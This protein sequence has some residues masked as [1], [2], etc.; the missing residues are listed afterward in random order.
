MNFT[1]HKHYVGGEMKS[2]KLSCKDA[3][4]L[5]AATECKHPSS[6]T[7]PP[8]FQSVRLSDLVQRFREFSMLVIIL[9]YLWF[10]FIVEKGMQRRW[11]V[12]WATQSGLTLFGC[13]GQACWRPA[14][15]SV[16]LL[17]PGQGKRLG[18]QRCKENQPLD[19]VFPT[20]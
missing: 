15:R 7:P 11:K 8:I 17:G 2:W 9:F 19:N 5:R 6:P 3:Y 20:K 16:P 1:T 14:V 4:M 13:K 18:G 10:C 12:L